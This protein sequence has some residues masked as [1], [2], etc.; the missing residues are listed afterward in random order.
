MKLGEFRERTQ[1][2]PDD[3][4]IVGGFMD[5]FDPVGELGELTIGTFYGPDGF[6]IE[7]D[8]EDEDT[9]HTEYE[10]AIRIRSVW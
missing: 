6:F 3:T 4:V 10:R 1:H 8:E 2:L 9:V 5:R 7:E